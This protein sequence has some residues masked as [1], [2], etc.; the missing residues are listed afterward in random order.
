MK[1]GLKGERELEWSVCYSANISG[2]KVLPHPCK[3][4]FSVFLKRYSSTFLS[5]HSV[6]YASEHMKGRAMEIGFND[7]SRQAAT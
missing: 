3:L 6:I 4:H 5:K 1:E 7:G 2:E